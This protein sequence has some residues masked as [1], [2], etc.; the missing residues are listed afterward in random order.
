[1][2]LENFIEQRFRIRC[3]NTIIYRKVANIEIVIRTS[4]QGT[5]RPAESFNRTTYSLLIFELIDN[6]QLLMSDL[7]LP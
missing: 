3:R 5:H 4:H 6:I 1:M 2:I 7:N